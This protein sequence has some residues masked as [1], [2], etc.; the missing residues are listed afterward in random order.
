MRRTFFSKIQSP[1]HMSSFC[2]TWGENL[3]SSIT[4]SW[5]SV[6]V[7]RLVK[8]FVNHCLLSLASAIVF[9]AFTCVLCNKNLLTYLLTYLVIISKLHVLCLTTSSWYLVAIDGQWRSLFLLFQ[10]CSSLGW[11]PMS[12]STLQTCRVPNYFSTFN[13][14]VR[15]ILF[16]PARC[17]ASA[18]YRDRNVSVCPSRAGI[19][20]KRRK[21]AAWFLHHLVA[22]IL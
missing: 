6:P 13:I 12:T 20:S 7:Y 21:L 18:G 4:P 1:D 16:L 22:P 3:E 9:Y 17:Y 2:V 14:N 5:T 10:W 19:V 15:S 11:L 8:S